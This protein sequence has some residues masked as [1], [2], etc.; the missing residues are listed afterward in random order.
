MIITEMVRIVI[1]SRVMMIE[2]TRG[3][4]RSD[5]DYTNVS[6]RNNTNGNSEPK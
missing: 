6:S 1:V 3:K 4:H 5:D 2:I